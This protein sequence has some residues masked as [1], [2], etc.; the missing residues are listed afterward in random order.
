MAFIVVTYTAILRPR[1]GRDTATRIVSENVVLLIE[2]GN[3]VSKM[4]LAC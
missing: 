2:I 3:I 1:Y 4:N